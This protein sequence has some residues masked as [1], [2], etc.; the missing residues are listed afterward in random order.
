MI[1]RYTKIIDT[2]PLY[3]YRDI[4]RGGIKIL[5][6]VQTVVMDSALDRLRDQMASQGKTPLFFVAD[7]RLLGMIALAD[8]VKPTSKEAVQELKNRGLK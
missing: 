2:H 8:V 6:S 3:G 4:K 7:R 5:R 1:P